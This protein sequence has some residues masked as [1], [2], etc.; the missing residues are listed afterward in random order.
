MK[1]KI[2]IKRKG[3]SK[4]KQIE[5]IAQ[6]IARGSFAEF[7]DV[8]DITLK[9]QNHAAMSTSLNTYSTIRNKMAHNLNGQYATRR[10]ITVEE[11]KDYINNIQQVV[12][13]LI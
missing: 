7:S 12:E 6:A 9:L 3:K 13:S 11:L 10:P 1:T 2:D 4:V 8:I 5:L